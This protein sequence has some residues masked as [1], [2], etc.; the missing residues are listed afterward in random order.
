[1]L[2]Y[3]E[4]FDIFRGSNSDER[5]TAH[6]CNLSTADIAEVWRRGSVVGAWLLDLT[7]IAL[8]E[9]PALSGY[10]GHVQDSGKGRWTLMAAI[11][12]A[13][14]LSAVLYRRFRSRQDHTFAEKNIVGDAL[15][16]WRSYRILRKTR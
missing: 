11:E 16:V 6:R 15:S 9:D 2:A 5:P 3:A 10:C 14:V 1:M 4:G 13:D 7:A 12:S 8:A